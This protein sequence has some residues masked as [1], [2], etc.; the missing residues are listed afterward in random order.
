MIVHFEGDNWWTNQYCA[1]QIV[2]FVK[3]NLIMEKFKLK[4]NDN[5]KKKGFNVY[6]LGTFI[7]KLNGGHISSN[8]R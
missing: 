6:L 8:L 2:N 3:I 5:K 7:E 4:L 1:K